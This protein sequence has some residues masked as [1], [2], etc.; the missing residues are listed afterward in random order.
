MEWIIRARDRRNSG[1]DSNRTKRSHAVY[2]YPV[3]TYTRN[4]G[5]LLLSHNATFSRCF[6]NAAGS[7]NLILRVLFQY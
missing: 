2:M 5:I 4:T 7:L 1:N 6:Y 3:A